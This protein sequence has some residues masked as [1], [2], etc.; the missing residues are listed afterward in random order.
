MVQYGCGQTFTC[1]QDSDDEFIYSGAD[2]NFVNDYINRLI[3]Q[4]IRIGVITNHNK[5]EK[6]EFAALKKKAS[7]H[8]I[9]LF[10]G[11]EFSLKEGIH[12]LIAFDEAWYK[13]GTV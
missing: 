4:E 3:D 12:I 6:D 10:P 1:I 2:N 11:I 9:G 5:F 8:T 7:E 13:G